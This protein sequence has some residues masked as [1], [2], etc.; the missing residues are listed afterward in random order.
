MGPG[1]PAKHRW[2][3]AGRIPAHEAFRVSRNCVTH[4]PLRLHPA[5]LGA[6]R[7]CS[8]GSGTSS[9]PP[10]CPGMGCNFVYT[11]KHL[12][13]W[14]S[15]SKKKTHN[16]PKHS[17]LHSTGA[18]C[19]EK[20]S[21][22]FKIKCTVE[23]RGWTGEAG[24]DWPQ[25]ASEISHVNL[26]PPITRQI[27]H[28]PPKPS[29]PQQR[30]RISHGRPLRSERRQLGAPSIA[31]EDGQQRDTARGTLQCFLTRR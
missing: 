2:V 31:L 22:S 30:C 5:D 10:P 6:F 14:K 11:Q 8:W 4:F 26:F 23:G 12:Y 25:P 3:P 16:L 29:H 19:K 18:K 28:P 21:P 20:R 7:P 13:P 17:T 15:F 1:G 9:I 24:M 27:C